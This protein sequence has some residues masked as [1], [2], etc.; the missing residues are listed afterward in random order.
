MWHAGSQKLLANN[1]NIVH[2]MNKF[3]GIWAFFA[4]LLFLILPN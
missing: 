4:M 3:V 1:V 2:Y